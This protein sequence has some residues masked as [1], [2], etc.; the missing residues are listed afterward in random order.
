MTDSEDESATAADDS[1]VTALAGAGPGAAKAAVALT[2]EEKVWEI[3][4]E[5]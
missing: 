4:V 5:M 1:M 3:H 2:D